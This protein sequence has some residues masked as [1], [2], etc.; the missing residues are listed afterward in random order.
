M[1]IFQESSNFWKR[2][3]ILLSVAEISC[4]L[5][6]CVL[7]LYEFVNRVVSLLLLKLT[8]IVFQGQKNNVNGGFFIVEI[9]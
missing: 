3:L 1:D 8:S 5:E 2:H 7:I 6:K 4:I 9:F